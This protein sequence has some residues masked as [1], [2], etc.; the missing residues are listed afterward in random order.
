MLLI[1]KFLLMDMISLC[2]LTVYIKTTR[3]GIASVAHPTIASHPVRLRH[4]PLEMPKEPITK[5]GT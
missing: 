2:P 4:Y 5:R 3:S 1:I